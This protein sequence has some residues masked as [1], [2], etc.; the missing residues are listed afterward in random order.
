MS[1]LLDSLATA[2]KGDAAR[3][4]VLD[5]ALRERELAPRARLPLSEI[6][7]EGAWGKGFK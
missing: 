1:A 5:D 2:F 4:S 6:A 7:F 3:R